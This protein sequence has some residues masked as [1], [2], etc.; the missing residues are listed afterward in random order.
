MTSLEAVLPK[1]FLTHKGEYLFHG[2]LNS[3]LQ[4]NQQLLLHNWH[5][6]MAFVGSAPGEECSLL[7]IDGYISQG[8][9]AIAMPGFVLLI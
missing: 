2:L 5:L 7:S 1:T 6:G 9:E 4:F 3:P 8:C